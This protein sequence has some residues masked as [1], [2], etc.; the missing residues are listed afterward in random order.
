MTRLRPSIGRWSRTATGTTIAEA[1][2]AA[3]P[4]NKAANRKTTTINSFATMLE[5]E[6]TGGNPSRPRTSP[7]TAPNQTRRTLASSGQPDATRGH[8]QHRVLLRSPPSPATTRSPTQIRAG[9][10]PQPQLG[11]PQ[12]PRLQ[13]AVAML[14]KTSVGRDKSLLLLS[15]LGRAIQKSK[16]QVRYR[17]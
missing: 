17:R 16:A 5:R 9:L 6:N 14:M 4:P 1:R 15:S 2:P 7:E 11:R 3:I 8:A 12:T 13:P 10:Q